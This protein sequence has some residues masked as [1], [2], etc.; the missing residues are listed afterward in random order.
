MITY[1][2]SVSSICF[3]TKLFRCKLKVVF[4]SIKLSL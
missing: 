4:Y 2:L 1:K 3:K